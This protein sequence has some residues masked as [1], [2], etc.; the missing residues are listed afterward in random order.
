LS[1]SNS[2][3]DQSVSSTFKA[4]N[5]E[6]ININTASAS[7]LESLWGI[8]PVYAQNIIEHRPYS[9]V[10]ELLEKKVL[11]ENVYERNKSLLTV[12]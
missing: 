7:E 4:E 12:N 1:A 9:K 6:L 11:K 5:G 10:E 2:G 8:G 3:V